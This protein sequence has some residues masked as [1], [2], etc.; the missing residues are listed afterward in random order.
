[1]YS[2]RKHAYKLFR[3]TK[4]KAVS[5]T[6]A[7][8]VVTIGIGSVLPALLPSASHAS[9][10]GA[11]VVTPANASTLGWTTDDTRPNGH[12]AYVSDGTAPGG[13]GALSMSRRVHQS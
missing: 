3:D 5:I 7:T 2:R 4:T 8:A 13:A 10:P 12:V 6:A 11:T 9:T 1:M